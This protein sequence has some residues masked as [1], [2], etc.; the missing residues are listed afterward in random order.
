MT[1]TGR[2]PGT[3]CWAAGSRGPGHDAAQALVA[4][5][6]RDALGEADLVALNPECC[7]SERGRPWDAPGKPFF[8]RTPPRAVELLALLGTDCVTLGQQP[9]PGLRRRCGR[10]AGS[11]RPLGGGRQ[12]RHGLSHG[13]NKSSCGASDRQL[14]PGYVVDIRAQVLVLRKITR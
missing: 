14:G 5:E 2:W 9:R 13:P 8:F 4:P 7:I 1:V 12:P 6:V 3:P 10:P 11:R